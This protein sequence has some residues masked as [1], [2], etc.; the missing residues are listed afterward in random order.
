MDASGEHAL[1]ANEASL[2]EEQRLQVFRKLQS[3]R[4][5]QQVY[6]P[7]TLVIIRAEEDVRK[8]LGSLLRLQR[9]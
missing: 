7:H 1:T 2:L 3:F 5:V 6:M 8:R 9:T 4:Q